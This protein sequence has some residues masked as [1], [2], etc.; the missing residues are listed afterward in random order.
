MVH[1]VAFFSTVPS[2]RISSV[3]LGLKTSIRQTLDFALCRLQDYAFSSKISR[4]RSWNNLA[5]HIHYLVLMCSFTWCLIQ[6]GR[7]IQWTIALEEAKMH[8]VLIT[9]HS[10][11][12]MNVI[13]AMRLGKKFIAASLAQMSIGFLCFLM[14]ISV[15]TV[16]N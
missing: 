14:F 7:C 11:F 13:N 15:L 4:I 9:N 8:F 3:A 12:Y 10:R 16:I 1:V 5:L 6:N 2:Q